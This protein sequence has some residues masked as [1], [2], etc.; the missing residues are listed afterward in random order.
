MTI[1]MFITDF[2]LYIPTVHEGDVKYAVEEQTNV[3][4]R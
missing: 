2:N 4:F 3:P 1:T